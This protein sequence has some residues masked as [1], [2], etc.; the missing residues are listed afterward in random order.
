MFGRPAAKMAA[1][2]RVLRKERKG[3]DR[4]TIFHPDI[5]AETQ[6]TGTPKEWIE[7]SMN[8]PSNFEGLVLGCIDSYDSDQR[9]I[10]QHF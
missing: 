10:L 1:G 4:D 8:S 5:S 2:R 7:Q 3:K 9:L 6:R